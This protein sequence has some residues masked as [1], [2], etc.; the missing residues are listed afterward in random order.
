MKKIAFLSAAEDE[1]IQSS[2]FYE[3]QTNG[4]GSDFLT[5]VDFAVQSIHDNP[6][7]VLKDMIKESTIA[8][9]AI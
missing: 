5:A 6:E 2:L 1:M 8:N 3:S 9:S 7:L 4:L